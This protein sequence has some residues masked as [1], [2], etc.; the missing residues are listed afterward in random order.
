MPALLAVRLL[1]ECSQGLLRAARKLAEHAGQTRYLRCVC[2]D[3]VA[4]SQPSAGQMD[5]AMEGVADLN[6][7]GA[8]AELVC[9]PHM[10]L[11]SL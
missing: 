2:W 4:F 5:S 6:L 8:A 9:A 3:Q 11:M 10:G 1:A 7:S